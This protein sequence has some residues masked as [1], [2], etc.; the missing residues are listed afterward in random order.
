MSNEDISP[1]GI[2]LAGSFQGWNAGSTEMTPVGDNVYEATLLI[3]EGSYQEYK[4]INGSSF[5]FTEAVPEECGTDDGQGGFNRYF[6]VPA[7]DTIME[8]VCF[9]SCG[10]CLPALPD[11]AVTF[12]V[13][14]T[15][16]DVSP[17]GVHLAGTFQDWNP[18][19]TEMTITTGSIYEVTLMLE[20]ASAHEFKYINGNTFEDAEIVPATCSQNGNRY[21]TVPAEDTIMTAVCFGSCDPCGPP[22]TDVYITFMVDMQLQSISPDGVHIAGDFQGWDPEATEMEWLNDNIYVYTT[23][24]LT[25][26]SASAVSAS[27][28]RLCSA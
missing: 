18:E 4:F 1:D 10:P 20:D 11:H 27:C 7:S 3:E 13:D 8:E 15:Y 12:R 28:R 17:E 5:D 2:H 22:P 9:S 19:I 24:L 6:T 23:T 21:F 16:Q 25:R 14:M 26:P